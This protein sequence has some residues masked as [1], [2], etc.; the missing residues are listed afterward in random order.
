MRMVETAVIPAVG[1]GSR[2]EPLTMAIPKEM[3]P[4]GHLPIIEHIIIELVSSGVKRICIVIRKGKEVI[5]EY[6]EKKRSIYKKAKF[7]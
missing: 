3:F 1:Y 4:L 5:K 2:M 7:H 6:L